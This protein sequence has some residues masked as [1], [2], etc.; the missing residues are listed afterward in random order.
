MR[1]A[2]TSHAAAR[3]TAVVR[4]ESWGSLLGDLYLLVEGWVERRRE[5]RALLEL[6]DALL[7]D[8]GLSRADALREASKPF[9]RR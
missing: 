5:R 7:K 9:W 2:A 1:N 6:D 3:E 4:A 8:I